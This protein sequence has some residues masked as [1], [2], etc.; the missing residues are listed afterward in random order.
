MALGAVASFAVG[1]LP[2]PVA[3][4]GDVIHF[5]DYKIVRD[6]LLW[7]VLVGGIF[8][9]VSLATTKTTRG[10]VVVCA[11]F[12]AAAGFSA[13]EQ[14]S[15]FA[16]VAFP[17]NSVELRYFWPRPSVRLNPQEIISADFE[18]S[19]HLADE[20]LLEYALHLR[21][22]RRHYVSF[23]DTSLGDVQR[24]LRRIQEMRGR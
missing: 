9:F 22:P 23:G 6:S 12:M 10:I 15:R 3:S 20:A 5:V 4:G 14:Y 2:R 17:D 19:V 11:L 8:L 13:W 21:T 18:R 24:A 16:A 1:F 7:C